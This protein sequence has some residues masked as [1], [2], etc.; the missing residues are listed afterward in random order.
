MVELLETFGR[1]FEGDQYHKSC[2]INQISFYLLELQLK[3]SVYGSHRVTII[4]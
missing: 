4:G 2:H 1:S 3:K